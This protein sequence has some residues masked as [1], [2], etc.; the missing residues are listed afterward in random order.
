M[1]LCTVPLSVQH[2]LLTWNRLSISFCSNQLPCQSMPGLSAPQFHAGQ[3]I[4]TIGTLFRNEEWW[5]DQY[6]D[7]HNRGYKLRPRYHPNWEPSW[8]RLGKDFF[9]VEDGQPCIVSVPLLGLSIPTDHITLVTCYDGCY[10][11]ARWQASH[12]QEDLPG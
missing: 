2:I 11:P 5:R 10:M 4:R 6:D 1:A 3:T 9:A 12:A 7:I 8:I